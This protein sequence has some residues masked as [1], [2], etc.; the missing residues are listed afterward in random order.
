MNRTEVITASEFAAYAETL[1]LSILVNLGKD[2]L[3]SALL[4]E[5][6][7]DTANKHRIVIRIDF[8]RS[9][10]RQACVKLNVCYIFYC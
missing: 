8:E 3:T 2:L 9:E 6:I 4:D 5:T 10:V 7:N 1:I